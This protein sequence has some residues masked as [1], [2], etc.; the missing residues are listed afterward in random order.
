MVRLKKSGKRSKDELIALQRSKK[1]SKERSNDLAN[2]KVKRQGKRNRKRSKLPRVE[3]LAKK[4]GSL[5]VENAKR[6]LLLRGRKTSERGSS[7][8]RDLNRLKK[9]HSKMFSKK[10]DILPFED[11]ASLRFL[12]EKNDTSLFGFVSHNKKR[13]HNLVLG[14]MFN[15]EILDMIELGI[16]QYLGLDDIKGNKKGIGHKP[17]ILFQGDEFEHDESLKT[18]KSL[19]IDIFRG[20]ETDSIHVAGLDSAL[21]CSAHKGKVHLRWYFVTLNESDTKAPAVSLSNHGP[22][23]DLSIRRCHVAPKELRNLAMKRPKQLKRKRQKNVSTNEMGD[24]VGRVYVDSCS[25][26]YRSSL[27]RY[28]IHTKN[29]NTGTKNVKL[30]MIF[31]QER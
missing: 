26:K 15:W 10:N 27:G 24:V 23:I 22:F 19:L 4:K 13:P 17:M 5:V 20:Q 2:E 11:D 21:V 9:P 3:R 29:A 31:R 6:M 14:R 28:R 7:L 25:E 1:V 8:L 16:D 18:L 12:C 30:W